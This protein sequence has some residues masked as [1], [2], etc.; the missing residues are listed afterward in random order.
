[1][2]L[3][4]DPP[5][6]HR[7]LV[8]PYLIREQKIFSTQALEP[9]DKEAP[10]HRFER[11]FQRSREIQVTI[12]LPFFYLN[13]E[14]LRN[15]GHQPVRWIGPKQLANLPRRHFHCRYSISTSRFVNTS[16]DPY[17]AE[18]AEVSCHCS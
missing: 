18:K 7:S 16:L 12:D 17:A 8:L 5:R 4:I 13:F 2:V 6:D 11:R 14:K 10:A 9:I 3:W 15:H 1:M